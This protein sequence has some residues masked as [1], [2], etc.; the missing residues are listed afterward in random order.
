M[1]ERKQS[2]RHTRLIYRGRCLAGREY[3][4]DV[5]S[6]VVQDGPVGGNQNVDWPLEYPGAAA[7]D[8]LVVFAGGP[9][10]PEARREIGPVFE[11]RRLGV[12]VYAAPK[13]QCQFGRDL[14]G[15][16]GESAEV[17]GP[18]LPLGIVESA[19]DEARQPK[20]KSLGAG[21]ARQRWTV[22]G[23]GD[24][25][26]P[27]ECHHRSSLGRRHRGDDREHAAREVVLTGEIK[28]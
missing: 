8:R 6:A 13:I 21:Q 2:R 22:V 7:D 11:R 1:A 4:V 17:V 14:P 19:M 10:E 25:T 3:L 28:V 27:V 9:G 15:V 18:A 16:L 24:G 5:F 20:S 23:D 26:R 12:E